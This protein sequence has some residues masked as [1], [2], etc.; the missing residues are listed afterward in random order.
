MT[1]ATEV[2]EDE[3]VTRATAA[4]PEAPGAVEDATV[5]LRGCEEEEGAADAGVVAGA[6]DKPG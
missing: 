4:V 6:E 1:W 5:V 2:L 3:S